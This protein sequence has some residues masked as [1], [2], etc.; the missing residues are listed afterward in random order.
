VKTGEAH[1]RGFGDLDQGLRLISQDRLSW[2]QPEL[3]RN[4]EPILLAPKP[5]RRPSG[6]SRL[7]SAG[8]RA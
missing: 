2:F 3:R 6:T 1:R 5:V 8:G 7:R 4:L